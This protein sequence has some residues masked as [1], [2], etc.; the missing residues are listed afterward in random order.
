[1]LSSPL[2]HPPFFQ[3]TSLFLI[4]YQHNVG[5]KTVADM[6]FSSLSL[7]LFSS[8]FFLTCRSGS[9]EPELRARSRGPEVAEGVAPLSLF[10]PFFSPARFFFSP[11]PSDGR[12]RVQETLI[13]V[14]HESDIPYDRFLLLPPPFFPVI[15]FS[16]SDPVGETGIGKGRRRPLRFFPPPSFFSEG[17][18]RPPLLAQLTPQK[19]KS[20]QFV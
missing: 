19:E 20:I 7:F 4:H 17:L 1:V 2:L 10:P 12:N 5:R 3:G 9:D 15:G 8:F 16:S 14:E 11:G 6:E 18:L 13:D